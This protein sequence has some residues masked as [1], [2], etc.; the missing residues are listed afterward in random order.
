MKARLLGNFHC[1]DSS[2]ELILTASKPRQIFALLLLQQGRVQTVQKLAEEIWRDA[3][4]V[5]ASTTLQTY[6]LQIRRMLAKSSIGELRGVCPKSLVK[7]YANGYLLQRGHITTDVDEFRD[8][9]RL[10]MQAFAEQDWGRAMQ[11]LEHALSLWEG[12]VLVD[13]PAGSVLRLE[14]LRLNAA[15]ADAER[16]RIKCA[17]ELGASTSVLTDLQVLVAEDPLN[18]SLSGL[19]MHALYNTM[20]TSPALDEFHRLRTALIREIGLEPGPAVREVRQLIL[21]G[22]IS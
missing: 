8:L 5:S 2:E 11:R 9:H 18:E 19:L 21:T 14:I 3:P 12:P 7:T 22:Q 4:P 13:V 16:I 20:G 6:V 10:G 17:I 1:I 15:R